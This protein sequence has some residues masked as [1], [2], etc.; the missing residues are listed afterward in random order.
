M[1]HR[2]L[3]ALVK[4]AAQALDKAEEARFWEGVNADYERLLADSSS[5]ADYERE[6]AEWDPVTGDGLDEE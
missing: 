6:L 1:R 3:R 4:A 2:M 5:R